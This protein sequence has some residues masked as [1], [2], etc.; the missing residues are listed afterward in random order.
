MKIW[1]AAVHCVSRD[2][3]RMR[4]ELCPSV[5]FAFPVVAT[6]SAAVPPS[7]RRRRPD[8]KGDPITYERSQRYQRHTILM[9][10]GF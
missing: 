6:S 2:K 7:S 8:T 9:D 5:L 3:V 4:Q 10:A 1:K